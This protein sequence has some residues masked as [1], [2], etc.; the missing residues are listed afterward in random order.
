MYHELKVLGYQG[1]ASLLYR[2]IRA[3][4][5]TPSSGLKRAFMP[6]QF[7][8]DEAAQFDWSTESAWIAGARRQFKLAHMKLCASRAFWLVA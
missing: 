6:L 7:E 1:S 5:E 2:Y 3:S 8:Y 4:K